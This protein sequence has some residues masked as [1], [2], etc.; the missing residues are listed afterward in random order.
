VQLADAR[1]IFLDRRRL[2]SVGLVHAID[3][4]TTAEDAVGARQDECIDVLAPADVLH[5]ARHVRLE[6]RRERIALFG[7]C[8]R[9]GGNSALDAEGDGGGQ[10]SIYGLS[11]G[12]GTFLRICLSAPGYS[13]I[14]HSVVGHSL[15]LPF[16]PAKLSRDNGILVVRL[17]SIDRRATL[18]MRPTRHRSRLPARPTDWSPAPESGYQP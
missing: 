17:G 2:D 18:K 15:C 16:Q 10:S 3:V 11:L 12:H 4:A 6:L 5:V 8:H 13:V 1:T 9:Q 7:T 14:M